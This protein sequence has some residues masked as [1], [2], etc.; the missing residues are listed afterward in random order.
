MK[1]Y[2]VADPHGFYTEMKAALDEKGFF[3]DAEPH[4]LIICGDLFDR[5]REA[6]QMQ[7]FILDF[8]EKN[9]AILIRGNHEDLTVDLLENWSE[10][11]YLEAHHF[12]NGTVDTVCQLTDSFLGDL[13]ADAGSIG[14]RF[15]NGPF[16]R[17]I[18]P[19]MRDY[20]ETEHYIFVHGWIPCQLQKNYRQEPLCSCFEDWRNGDWNVARWINGMEAA[21]Y[22][23]TV[24]DKTVVCGHWHTSFGHCNYE[25]SGSEF[26]DDADF[27]PYIAPGIIALDACTVHS[28]KVNCIVLED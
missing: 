26:G 19:V 16:M 20:Y 28:H 11:S 3:T 1:Y 4:R 17:K 23:I 5:G 25:N 9:L 21:H 22:G 18:I 27:S 14:K 8:M 6:T 15:E 7:E 13:Y 2:V 10:R 24:P 12:S